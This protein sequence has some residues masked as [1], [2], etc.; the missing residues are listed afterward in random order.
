MGT[1]I[2]ARVEGRDKWGGQLDFILSCL[3]Y[4]VGLGNVWRFPY[5]CGRSGGAA[6]LIPYFIMMLFAGL[7]T[8][9]MELSIGQ[10]CSLAP[11]IM[12]RRMCPLFAGIGYTMITI[13]FFTAIY[14]NMIIAWSLFYL[15]AS[16]TSHLPWSHCTNYWNTEY[17]YDDKIA[18]TCENSTSIYYLGVC[19]NKTLFNTSM[20]QYINNLTRIQPADEYLNKRVLH[21]SDGIGSLGT[22]SWELLLSLLGAWILIFFCLMHGVKS[23]GKVVYFT[24]TFPY[25]ILLALLIREVTLPGAIDGIKFYMVP[26]MTK[27]K[28]AKVWGDAAVQIF[29]SLSVGGGGLTTLASYNQFHNNLLRDTLIVVFGNCLTS[30]FAGFVIFSILGFVSNQILKDVKEI[31]AS[32]PSL[33]FVAYPDALTRLPASPVWA[34]LFFFMLILL[35]IDSQLVIVEV[36]ITC[37]IDQWPGL[38]PWRR[39]VWVV[40]QSAQFAFPLGSFSLVPLVLIF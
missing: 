11:H 19:S 39:K 16:F 14:Y 7:P 9:F 28:E 29:F 37:I 12:Y 3:G 6:F 38:R 25:V 23:S 21:L 27:L 15:G 34:V 17:C 1:E 31:A 32:G 22:P 4:A 40:V 26:N 2:D 33:A 8:F 18:R 20:I 10:Y 24:A 30:I 5:L 36:V 13:S 35:G